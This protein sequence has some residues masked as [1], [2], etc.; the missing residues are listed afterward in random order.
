ML[1]A[2]RICLDPSKVQATH[3]AR[4]AGTARFAYNWALNE[5][6]RQYEAYKGNPTLPKPNAAALRRQL[7]AI[8]RAQFPWM[9]EVT[10]NAPQ[11]AIIQLGRAFQN[12]FEKR[13][14]YPK[15]RRKGCDDRFSV[16]NDQ[17]RI[18]GQRIRIPKLGWLKMREALRFSGRIISAS[19]SRVADH[20]YAS[21]TVDTELRPSQ[22]ENQ[23]A[24][25]I[26]LGVTHL[27]T[28]STGEIVSGPKALGALLGRVRRLSRS[29][30]RKIKGSRN[31]NKARGKL[32]RL[33]CRIANVRAN[34][35]HQFTTSI[36]RRFHTIGIEDLYVK[37]MLG[38]RRLSRAVADMGFSTLR[39]QLEYKAK[40]YGSQVII[41]D[42]WYASS[43][44]CSSCGSKFDKLSLGMRQWTCPECAT[45]HSRDINA[46][47]NLRNI[48]VSSTVS[49]CRGEGT[50]PARERRA[51]PA[52]V[53]Q[54]PSKEAGCA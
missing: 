27:A 36:T 24:V 23:G 30:S 35:L 7:N 9:L 8:K 29:L 18:A 52:P 1:L 14:R 26:D 12:F 11:M 40:L 22:A 2:H 5:W 48:A 54:E 20:W 51:K 41:A 28:L 43:K 46:A 49:A 47:I 13:A 19:I 33:H 44:T 37:G 10:K 42:R 38:N 50:G 15:F 21:V 6:Q 3:L 32:A 39:R 45:L 53:K 31:R 34:G 16:T 4:A 17:L 25:G